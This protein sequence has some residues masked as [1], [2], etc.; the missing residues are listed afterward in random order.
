MVSHVDVLSSE[1]KKNQVEVWPD[2]IISSPVEEGELSLE[3]RDAVMLTVEAVNAQG[4]RRPFSS[5][6]YPE[7]TIM[8]GMAVALFN[9]FTIK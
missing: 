3:S 4:G 5:R 9:H 6:D 8:D 7:F 1:S 2:R